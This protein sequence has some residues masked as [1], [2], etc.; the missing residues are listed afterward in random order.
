M[1]K[2]QL[3]ISYDGT[4]FAGWQVQKSEHTVAGTLEKTFFAIFKTQIRILASSRTDAGVHALAQ[5]A[6]FTLENAAIENIEPERIL[7]IWNSSLPNSILIRK[8]EICDPNFHPLYKVSSKTYL[9]H[10]ATQKFL[11]FLSPYV[12]QYKADFDLNKINSCL[13]VFLG[14]HDFRSFCT[15]YEKRNTVRKIDAIKLNYIKRYNIYQFEFTGKGFLR[16]MVRR[17]VGALLEA[18][19]KDEINRDTLIKALQERNPHQKLPTV[20]SH[21]LVLYKISYGEK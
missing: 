18:G 1:K 15:G 2:F 21:G 7:K 13:D 14:E 16:H 19:S 4:D 8:L 6:A 17:I 3:L 10:I 12:Y 11:P 9:Y 5:V 20:P